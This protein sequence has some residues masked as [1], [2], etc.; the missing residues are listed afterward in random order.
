MHGG[1]AAHTS[2]CASMCSNWSMPLHVQQMS[3]AVIACRSQDGNFSNALQTVKVLDG[4]RLTG[5]TL[6]NPRSI[7]SLPFLDVDDTSRFTSGLG[8]GNLTFRD[9]ASNLF[10]VRPSIEHQNSWLL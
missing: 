10:L 9:Q 4:R 7:A 6:Q 8:Q 5:D 2:N 1:P 3:V